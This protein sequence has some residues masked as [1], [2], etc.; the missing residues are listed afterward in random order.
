MHG[1]I[2]RYSFTLVKSSNNK[3]VSS[4]TWKKTKRYFNSFDSQDTGKIFSPK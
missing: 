4:K 1:W 2:G 3:A